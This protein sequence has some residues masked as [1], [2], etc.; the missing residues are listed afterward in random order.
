MDIRTKH[1]SM[2][3][4]IDDAMEDDDAIVND[5]L[6]TATAPTMQLPPL[7]PGVVAPFAAPT[8][9]DEGAD[10][11]VCDT[12]G[13][14]EP[15][16]AGYRVTSIAGKVVKYDD[17]LYFADTLR[18]TCSLSCPSVAAAAARNGNNSVVMGEGKEGIFVIES[19][20][21]F[22]AIEVYVDS[23]T[24]W[25]TRITFHRNGGLNSVTV[26]ATLCEDTICVSPARPGAQIREAIRLRGVRD[27]YN[28]GR[29]P[30]TQLEVFYRDGMGRI[31]TEHGA[32]VNQD[33]QRQW[34]RVVPAGP[35][36]ALPRML[37][38]RVL[39]SGGAGGPRSV[40]STAAATPGGAS[41]R[42]VHQ[43]PSGAQYRS[44]T[45]SDAVALARGASSERGGLPSASVSSVSESRSLSRPP[46]TT[47]SGGSAHHRAP[48]IAGHT[49]APDAQGGDDDDDLINNLSLGGNNETKSNNALP[50]ATFVPPS[51]DNN[52]ANADATL[53]SAN[54]A[55]TTSG[56]TGG[57]VSSSDAP[58]PTASSTIAS[59]S[60]SVSKNTAGANKWIYGAGAAVVGIIILVF[61]IRWKRRRDAQA[62][63]NLLGATT[64][65]ALQKTTTSS[66][67]P[68]AVS[69]SSTSSGSTPA[70]R[71]AAA[72]Q[73]TP[74]LAPRQRAGS[75]DMMR[76]ALNS[77]N[78]RESEIPPSP[79]TA[80][81]TTDTSRA[82]YRNLDETPAE[83]KHT[84]W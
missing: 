3:P 55:V 61:L 80:P 65:P 10:K 42:Q 57:V 16:M 73:L 71:L 33:A 14:D 12:E 31:V 20:L 46:N 56:A 17:R 81:L 26:G 50:G 58:M 45:R 36:R 76:R 84:N 49:R 66:A 15:C 53:A 24:R 69:A 4:V 51:S 9:V 77:I 29:L 75:R 41:S 78:A 7:P 83:R 64:P 30:L 37:A 27:N 35:P 28:D 18:S 21:G 2:G 39:G 23:A 67:V 22:N 59:S 47:N 68:A 72:G 54:S 63:S 82:R 43:H 62:A 52:N 5:M 13:F 8:P 79:L 48:P 32:V 25:I 6:D 74:Q 60:S 1:A 70:A 38:Q 34:P 19:A 11:V 40:G 44:A